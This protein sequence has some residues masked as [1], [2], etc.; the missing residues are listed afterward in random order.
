MH[1]AW[2]TLLDRLLAGHD[3][4]AGAAAWAM[5]E[6]VRGDATPAQL[7]ALLVA[8]RAK[9]ETADEL[10]GFADA[11]LDAAPAVPIPGPT[12]DIA[13]TGG[14]GT[15]AV[16]ISTMAAIVAAAA[17]ARVVKHGGRAASATS[18]GSADVV[19]RLGVPLDLTPAAHAAVAVDA[20]ITF[21]FAAQVHPGMRHASPVRREL[22]VPTVF[23]ALGPLINPAA[24]THRLVGVAFAA[25][26]PL[27]AEVLR[28]RGAR[29]LVVRGDDG[30][31]KLSTATTSQVWTVR[32]GAAHREVLDPAALGIPHPAPGAL[33]GGDAEANARVVHDLL[34]G[35]PGAV[36]DAVLL[37]AAAALAT[38]D[39]GP[40]LQR[41]RHQL[42]RCAAAVDSGA[43]A[44]TLARWVTT[45]QAHA[46]YAAA[47][48]VGSGPGPH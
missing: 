1:N 13:G 48:A 2:P 42:E 36:R 41:L 12:L 8:L 32:D 20:G 43:A 3:L 35:R 45:A 7:A 11:L 27:L 4:T 47:G 10:G 28:A 46:G 30:L 19:E 39:D 23:N 5:G 18:A 14:D 21:L 37:N 22:G 16:N 34:A 15:N 17:G 31:D 26:L 33:R 6:V 24:P 9:G 29:A 25:M 38:F 40:L 44:T